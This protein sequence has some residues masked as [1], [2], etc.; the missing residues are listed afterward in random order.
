MNS[1]S[2]TSGEPLWRRPWAAVYRDAEEWNVSRAWARACIVVP[3]VAAVA[4]GLLAAPAQMR[5]LYRALVW[6]DGI[7]EWIQVLLVC[8]LIALGFD[9]RRRLA[10]AGHV[11]FS[12]LYLGAALG[13]LFILGEEISW[14]QRLFG[15]ATPDALEEVNAQGE[16]NLHNIRGVLAI[17]NMVMLGIAAAAAA[18]PIAW[19]I[20]AGDRPRGVA[21]ALLVPPLFVVP[22]FLLAVSYRVGRMI[23]LPDAPPIISRYQEVTETGFYFGFLVF[24]WVVARRLRQQA[25]ADAA[26]RTNAAAAAR[27]RWTP[28]VDRRAQSRLADRRLHLVGPA[29][30]PSAPGGVAGGPHAFADGRDR[31]RR[32]P[33]SRQRLGR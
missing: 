14:G 16:T 18:L 33:E 6:E 31:R 20:R 5:P 17:L 28:A 7:V 29:T 27:S 15:W 19:R 13:A 11:W 21:E 9:I 30:R 32:P 12:R 2:N 10:R 1:V 8:G 24:A 4:I 26:R 25:A 23:W 3:V 22:A